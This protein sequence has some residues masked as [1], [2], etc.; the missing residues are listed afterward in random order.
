MGNLVVVLLGETPITTVRNRQPLSND[1]VARRD[2][3]VFGQGILDGAVLR[4]Q[5]TH[6]SLERTQALDGVEYRDQLAIQFHDVSRL[7]CSIAGE[8]NLL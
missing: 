6:L 7:D 1:D 2:T 4:E 3:E 5:G 8:A